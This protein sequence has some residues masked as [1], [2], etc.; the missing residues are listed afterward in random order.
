MKHR[1]LEA[2]WNLYSRFESCVLR[3]AVWLAEKLGC[4]FL[5]IA[6]NRPLSSVQPRDSII[7]ESYGL[8][9]KRRADEGRSQRGFLLQFR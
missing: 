2:Q 9:C 1:V 8:G 7:G 4:M 3:H 5:K 6:G